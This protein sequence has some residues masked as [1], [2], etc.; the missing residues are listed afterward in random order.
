MKAKLNAWIAQLP[1]GLKP[2]NVLVYTL[3]FL[4]L[5]IWQLA[6]RQRRA[7]GLS[8]VE[9]QLVADDRN[10]FLSPEVVRQSANEAL[11]SAARRPLRAVHQSLAETH[12]LESV[13]LTRTPDHRLRVR[14]RVRRPVARVIGG[15]ASYY[16][17]AAGVPFPLS[18]TFAARVL[19]LQLPAAVADTLQPE[20]RPQREAWLAVA[21]ELA[22]DSLLSGLISDIRVTETGEGA[23][24]SQVGHL[25]FQFGTPDRAVEKL[26][27]L[28]SFVTT[29]LPHT[30]WG[31]YRE[32]DLRYRGQVLG[33]KR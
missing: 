6:D 27:A 26:A 22:A 15:R 28:R 9:V 31:L 12:Y 5:G 18:K 4:S 11:T 21:R 10:A 23:L 17:D 8:E 13:E 7:T 32:V 30:G 24:H 29:V 20:G 25:Q 16:V 2:H 1:E 14:A 3:L 19:V 33:R